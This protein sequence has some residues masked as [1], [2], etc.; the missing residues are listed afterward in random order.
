MSEHV[1][2]VGHGHTRVEPWG[3]DVPSGLGVKATEGTWRADGTRPCGLSLSARSELQQRNQE[4]D[5]S[6]P[7][8]ARTNGSEPP[9]GPV[10]AHCRTVDASELI[11]SVMFC[12]CIVFPYSHQAAFHMGG[13]GKLCSLLIDCIGYYYSTCKNYWPASFSLFTL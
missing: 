10:V 5:V 12:P 1:G 4:S 11:M 6:P 8:G 9:E 3:P 2:P 13:K 7:D